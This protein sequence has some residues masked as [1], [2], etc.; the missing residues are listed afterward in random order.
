MSVLRRFDC[1]RLLWRLALCVMGHIERW[2][3]LWRLTLASLHRRKQP[4]QPFPILLSHHRRSSK[5]RDL[6]RE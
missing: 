3:A 2:C 6:L 1:Y 4:I 5:E